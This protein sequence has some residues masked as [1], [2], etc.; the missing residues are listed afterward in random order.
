MSEQLKIYN[1]SEN[2]QGNVDVRFVTNVSFKKLFIF[3]LPTHLYTH[4]VF[5]HNYWIPGA[6]P[7]LFS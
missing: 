6:I 3:H 4:Q 7:L 5:L 1:T 2:L